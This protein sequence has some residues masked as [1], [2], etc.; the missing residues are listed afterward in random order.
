[1]IAQKLSAANFPV[2]RPLLYCADASIIGTPFYA[3]EYVEGR[4]LTNLNGVSTI[5]KSL[6]LQ[7][8]AKAL[9][10]LHS[11]SLSYLG[12]GDLQS[13]TS[14]YQTLNKKLYNTYKLHETKISTNVE[15]LLYW[16]PLNS[17]VK[18]ESDNLCLVHGD[19]SIDKVIFHPTEPKILAIV[20]W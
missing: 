16:L 19:I 7:E 5:E 11:I 1:M 17:P 15:D 9:A 3:T 10:H 8:V 13:E 2:P 4:I 12:L 20:D 18:S 6:L 14:Q